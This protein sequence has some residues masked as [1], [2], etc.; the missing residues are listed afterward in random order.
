MFSIF[1]LGFNQDLVVH[2]ILEEILQGILVAGMAIYVHKLKI[3]ATRK[4]KED[5]SAEDT[6]EWKS[7]L[8]YFY[9]N[10]F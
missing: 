9:Q 1:I 8:F 6:L 4:R 2:E 10:I 3:N 5:Y 7:G